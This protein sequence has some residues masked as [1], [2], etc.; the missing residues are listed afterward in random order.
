MLVLGAA[1]VFQFILSEEHWFATVR[2]VA[3]VITVSSTNFVNDKNFVGSPSLPL[4][5][6][7]TLTLFFFQLGKAGSC[8]AV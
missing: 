8:Y 1:D 2:A 5:C 7:S 3:S 4:T 6:A